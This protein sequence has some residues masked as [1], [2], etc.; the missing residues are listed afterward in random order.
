MT[1]TD[2]TASKKQQLDEIRALLTKEYDT[3][4]ARLR[5]L[6]EM[7]A[8]TG[9]PSDALQVHDRAALVAAT[10]QSLEQI[11]GALQRIEDGTYG[12]CEKCGK[13]IPVERLQVLPH[14]RFCVPCQ[15]RHGR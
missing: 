9:D 11:K 3:H 4:T 14:A 1:D 5:E 10:R 13:T 2:I 7:T 15:E 6:E 12:Q 8:D